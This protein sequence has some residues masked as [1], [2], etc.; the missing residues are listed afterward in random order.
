MASTDQPEGTLAIVTSVVGKTTEVSQRRH[1]AELFGGR[2]VIVCH[3]IDPGFVADRP[4][5]HLTRR[6]RGLADRAEI[7]LG[8]AWG[9]LRWRASG[10]PFGANRRRLEAF[11]REQRV[12]AI[13]AEFGHLGSNFAPIG[14]ALGIPTFVY[15]RGFDAS[16]RL[17]SPLRVISYRAAIPRLAGWFAVSRS[18]LDNLAAKGLAHPNAHVIPSGVDTRLFRPGEKDPDLMLAVGRMIPKKA[19]LLTVE[20]FA[21]L[22]PDFPRA[23]LEMVGDGPLLEPARA[24]AAARGVADRV[25]FLGMRPHAEVRG[26]MARAAFFLQHSLTDEA[27][28]EEGLPIA[29]QEAMASGAVVV[30]T[31][32]AGIP[33]AVVEDETGLL[34][35]EGDLD[36]YAA[37]IRSLA[38]DPD[39]RRAFA[40]AARA[41]A[42]AEFDTGVL[43]ARLERIIAAAVRPRSLPRD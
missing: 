19:P 18:L 30:S 43:Q 5:L 31:R 9:T 35:D 8:K 25:A 33:D 27:G 37:A 15:F 42:E 16:K 34:V 7:E 29:I 36:G 1:I 14:A 13:L 32:H 40:A 28:N 21:R 11:L 22:A 3:S 6:P 17:S 23:R 12:F 20:A 39:R 38:A 41:R 4:M 24:L 26:L 2:T 10:V